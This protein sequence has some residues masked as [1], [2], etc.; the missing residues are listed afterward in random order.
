MRLIINLVLGLIIAALIYFLASS[1]YEPIKFN[2]E[3]EVREDAVVEKL[4]EI[5]TAQ[6]AYRGIVGEYAPTF[7]T[8]EQVLKTDSFKIIRVFG[9]PDEENAK[10]TKEIF[11]VQAADSIQTLGINLDSLR[12]VPFSSGEEFKVTAANIEYQSTTVPVV[13]VKTVIRNYM[14]EYSAPKY[15]RYDYSYKPDN[16]RKFGDLSKPSTAGN[17]E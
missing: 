4:Q 10:I 17:W 1:I 15:T 5:R 11:Y 14:G 2:A 8:L 3:R 7:D 12:F 6:L 16:V 9:N 13:E